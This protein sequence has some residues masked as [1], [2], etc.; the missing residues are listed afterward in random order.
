MD[1]L[2][3]AAVIKSGIT[4]KGLFATMGEVEK[5][6]NKSSMVIVD[7]VYTMLYDVYAMAN[8]EQIR[9]DTGATG[10]IN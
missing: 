10:S 3:E 4:K 8:E 2:K 5:K 9:W 6:L 7:M 1:I